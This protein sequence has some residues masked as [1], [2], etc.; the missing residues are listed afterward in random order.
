MVLGEQR[1]EQRRAELFAQ[2]R[3]ASRERMSEQSSL[4]LACE[5]VGV[6]A[7]SSASVK[8]LCLQAAKA[9]DLDLDCWSPCLL[10]SPGRQ[11][12]EIS[13]KSFVLKD[14]D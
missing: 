12:R 4:L 11:A 2:A 3:P 1:A 6:I 8:S 7:G 10:L 5:P 14:K 13:E 9:Q